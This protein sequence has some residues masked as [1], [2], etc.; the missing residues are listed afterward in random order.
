MTMIEFTLPSGGGGLAPMMALAN[1]KK[2][3]AEV[4]SP[5]NLEYQTKIDG[6]RFR[7]TFAKNKH[8]TMFSM[9]WTSTRFFQEYRILVQIPKP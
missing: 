7:V 1:L 2:K 3:L 5:H 8:F 6:H 9:L 4:C